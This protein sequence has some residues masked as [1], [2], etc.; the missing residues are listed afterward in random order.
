LQDIA[1][2]KVLQRERQLEEAEESRRIEANGSDDVSIWG[3]F[4]QWTDTFN[5]KDPAVRKKTP[6]AHVH[7]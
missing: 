4:M 3:D 7:C 1:I 5:G 6:K 2:E